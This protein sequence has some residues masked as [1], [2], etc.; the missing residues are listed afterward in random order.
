[1]LIFSFGCPIAELL[2]LS[3]LILRF[4]DLYMI[5]CLIYALSLSNFSLDFELIAFLFVI[6]GILSS[7]S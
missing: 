1:M 4:G 2:T 6:I 3:H 7:F 5:P